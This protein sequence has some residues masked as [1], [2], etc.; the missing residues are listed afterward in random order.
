MVDIIPTVMSGS[1]FSTIWEEPGQRKK[2]F[3]N[4]PDYII[5]KQ[6]NLIVLCF[7]LFIIDVSNSLRQ[8]YTPITLQVVRPVVVR[9][10]HTPKSF[11]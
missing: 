9:I 6:K 8:C 1:G 10:G 5:D 11:N 3:R 7:L 2:C 4:E